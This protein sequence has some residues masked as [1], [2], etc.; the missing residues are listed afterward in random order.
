MV[1]GTGVPQENHALPC[2][3]GLYPRKEWRRV[4]VPPSPRPLGWATHA[5]PSWALSP[6]AAGAIGPLSQG[7]AFPAGPSHGASLRPLPAAGPQCILLHRKLP[8]MCRPPLLNWDQL[9]PARPAAA[10]SDPEPSLSRGWRQPGPWAAWAGC[11]EG[12]GSPKE[13]P[14]WRD[15]EFQEPGGATRRACP[16]P[17]CCSPAGSLRA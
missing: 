4:Q 6:A 3:G 10:G 2:P 1:C 14:Q 17:A 16:C 8:G 5:R 11:L 13:L 15:G 9:F 12:W 7:S